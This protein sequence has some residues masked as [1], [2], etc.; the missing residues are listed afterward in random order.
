MT[1]TVT[2]TSLF[3]HDTNGDPTPPGTPFTLTPIAIAPGNTT[4]QFGEGG[5]LD[6]VEFTV[7]LNLSDEGKVKDDDQIAVRGRTCFARVRVWRSPWSARGGIEVLCHS[8]TG[9]AG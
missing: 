4:R 6:D 9:K 3:G 5:D 2:V 8:A 1:E 7:Y